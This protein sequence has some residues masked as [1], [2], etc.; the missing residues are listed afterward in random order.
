[1]RRNWRR[2]N[3]ECA[4]G[5][6]LLACAS[7]GEAQ[8]P[9]TAQTQDGWQFSITPYLWMAGQSG[10]VRIG[11]TIP[12]QNVDASFSNIWRNLD[13]GVMGTF[14][15]RKGRW[16]IIVDGFYVSVSKTSDPILGGELGTARGKLDNGV[17]EVAGAY[18]VLQ[19]DRVPV[20]VLAGLR[21]TNLNA[22]LSF[23]PSAILPAGDERSKGV[24]WVDG[25]VGVRATYRFTDTWSVMGYADAGTGGTRYSWQ[26]VG[27]LF[28][29]MTKNVD[30]S[31]GYRI[32]AQDYNTSSFYYNIRTAGPFAGVRVRF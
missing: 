21:Y 16:G 4:T 12:A 31:G 26:L 5:V 2:L 3:R 19:S 24:N 22:S 23:S 27:V 30:L 20:D 11:Q 15:A 10:S 13:F 7:S 8:Q 9:S 6:V 28:W 1:M 32:L 17:V 14:E 29:N 18:R 25:L